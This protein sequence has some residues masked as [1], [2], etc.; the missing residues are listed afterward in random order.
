[1]KSVSVAMAAYNGEQYIQEQ[2]ASI[3]PQLS[4]KDEFI[5]S[6]DESQDATKQIIASFDDPRIQIVD[7]PN[8]GVI[9]NFEN[10]ISHTNNDIIFLAD[11]DD[12]WMPEKV[13]KVVSL[14]HDD[15]NVVIHDCKITD[16]QL[17]VTNESFFQMRDSKPGILKNILKNSYIGA[18][19]AFRK[20][21]KE[22]CLP[23]PKEIPMHDQWI[24]LVGECTGTNVFLDQPYIYYRRHEDN[25]TQMNHAGW[26]QMIIWRKQIYTS[27]KERGLL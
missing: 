9:A 13:D 16:S 11:Q 23:F 3:L 5:I 25:M 21:L 10:A 8:Q 12:V 22:K 24:G 14:F 27:L 15:V 1:M 20:E 18:C 19:M 17:H 4:E 26:M 6:L 7:G 2:I